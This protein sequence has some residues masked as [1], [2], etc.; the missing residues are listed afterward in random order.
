MISVK[1]KIVKTVQKPYQSYLK[2]LESLLKKKSISFKK[3]INQKINQTK[4]MNKELNQ[5]FFMLV[6]IQNSKFDA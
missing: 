3:E 2:K 5:L 1:N 6:F 4:T